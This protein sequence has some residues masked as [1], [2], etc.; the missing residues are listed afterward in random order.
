VR[1]AKVKICLVGDE[2]VG[3]T[4]LIRRFV[5][6]GFSEDYMRTMGAVVSKKSLDF[7]GP[8]EP[9]GVDLMIW[10]IIGRREFVDLI[11]DAYF[12][13]ANGVIAVCDATRR[14][15]FEDLRGWVHGVR[16]TAGAVPVLI[17]ANKW[18]LAG[19]L[20]VSQGE[21]EALGRELGAEVL[22]TSAR[23]GQNVEE[24]FHRLARA[25]LAQMRS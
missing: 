24:G 6:G 23:T 3:K 8:G 21:L 18:D 14:Q 1:G 16:A 20:Q 2:G 12:Q 19:S 22:T 5:Q 17:F 13:F 10:D 7:P 11:S 9:R 4:S 25:I 15:T